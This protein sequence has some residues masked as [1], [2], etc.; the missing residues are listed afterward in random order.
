[1][2]LGSGYKIKR[3]DSEGNVLNWQPEAAKLRLEMSE[4]TYLEQE[5]K[6]NGLLDKLLKKGK[7]S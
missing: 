5:Q 1:M 7:Q 3:K 6:A 2:K 4:V